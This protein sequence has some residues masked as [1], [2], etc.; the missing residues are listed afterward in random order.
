MELPIYST[1][2]TFLSVFLLFMLQEDIELMHSLGVNS[3][4]F[5]IAWTRILPSE[6]K[7]HDLL[8]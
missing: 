1:T 4:R 8:L 5:S 7:I 6:S 3:Y 2:L